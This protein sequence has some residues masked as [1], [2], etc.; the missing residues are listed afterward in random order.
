[1]NFRISA[2]RLMRSLF[3]GL[4]TVLLFAGTALAGDPPARVV[5]LKYI[6][7]QV[8]FQPGGV[9][10]WVEAVMNRPLTTADRLWADKD[11]RA[12]LSLGTAVLR[13]KDE[14]SITLTNVDD[15]IVQ[16]EL[17][18]GTLNLHVRHMDPGET[19][20]IDTPNTAFTLLKPGDY[21]FEV[22]SEHGG[23]VVIVRK[24]EGEATGEGSGVKVKSG[25]EVRFENGASEAGETDRARGLD[26]FDDWCRVRDKREDSAESLRYV[27]P[28]MVGYE[29]LDEY[30]GWQVSVYGPVWFPRHVVVGWSPYHY[31]HWVWIE[32]WGW[33]WVDDAPWGFAPFHYGRWVSVGGVWGWSPGPARMRPVYAPALVAWVGGR[34]WSVGIGIGGGVGWVPLGYGEAYY[35]AYHVSEVYVRNVNIT[36]T[37]ITNVTVV[38]NNYTRIVNNTTVINERHMNQGVAGGVTVVSHDAFVN[39]RPVAGAAVRLNPRDAANAQVMASAQVAP[40]RGSVLGAGHE[41]T[42]ALPPSNVVGRQV[43]AKQ[44]PPQ[45]PVAFDR[46]QPV[47]ERNAGRP[48][49]DSQVQQLRSQRTEGGSPGMRPATGGGGAGKVTANQPQP[50][51]TIPQPGSNTMNQ[52]KIVGQPQERI[53]NSDTGGPRTTNQ[54]A[55]PTSPAADTRPSNTVPRPRDRVPTQPN[56]IG[57]P[58]DRTP[59]ADTS[60]QRTTNTATRP[61][62]SAAETQPRNNAA[63]PVPRPPRTYDSRPQVT[64]APKVEDRRPPTQNQ[65]DRAI[66]TQPNRTVQAPPRVE[67]QRNADAPKPQ[68]Q[69]PPRPTKTEKPKEEKPKPSDR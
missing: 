69:P 47:L 51:R 61:T 48:L 1:M 23:T 12:E 4:A 34:N 65:P 35:P 63:Q 60:G 59:G 6:S 37:R 17:D 27:S 20:E 14:T 32:P 44:P 56:V 46:R 50:A 55:R 18:Q 15:S 38:T 54:V 49:D 29:D 39:A 7:G 40:V 31:G 24:G 26:G 36:N 58:M 57:R 64:T 62:P 21:R 68:R 13:I 5:R 8:S 45:R 2:K 28:D 11:S 52:P 10:D 16:V 53:P 43:W 9:N 67:Q 22:D 42:S 30:G 19:Y 41:R 25:E 3:V 66:N 33:T